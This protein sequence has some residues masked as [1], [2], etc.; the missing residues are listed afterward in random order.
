[1]MYDVREALAGRIGIINLLGLLTVRCQVGA[2]H[3]FGNICRQLSDIVL[4]CRSITQKNGIEDRVEWC[5][6]SVY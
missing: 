3:V 6:M 4:I 2:W 1:M 5:Q